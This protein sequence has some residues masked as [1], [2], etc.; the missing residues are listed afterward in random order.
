MVAEE[1]ECLPAGGGGGAGERSVVESLKITNS[2]K[3]QRY[4]S[5]PASQQMGVHE[6]LSN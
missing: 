5:Q 3:S 4:P 1:K 2:L 6:N